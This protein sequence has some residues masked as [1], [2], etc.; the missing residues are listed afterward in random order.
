MKKAFANYKQSVELKE[1]GFDEDCLAFFQ[2]EKFEDYPVLVDDNNQY[3]QTGYRTCKNSEIP[4]H[5]IAAPL[6][7]QIF[8]VGKRNGYFTS[9]FNDQF[10]IYIEFSKSLKLDNNTGE[11]KNVYIRTVYHTEIV[12][13]KES[14][15]ESCINKLIQ[16]LKSK[17]NLLWSSRLRRAFQPTPSTRM[18]SG[19]WS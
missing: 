1:L 10:I 15:E 12:D 9:I 2:N 18:G 7:S 19:G 14:V 4:N 17:S 13:N 5:F 11:Y 8:D 3:R 6:K 16:I